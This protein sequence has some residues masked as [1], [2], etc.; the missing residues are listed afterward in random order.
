[1]VADADEAIGPVVERMYDRAYSQ[2]PVY[3][4][5]TLIGL[6]TS[7][8]IA[9]WLGSVQRTSRPSMATVADVLGVA[10]SGL[11]LELVDQDATVGQALSLFDRSMRSGTP[12]A[13]VLVTRDAS[14]TAQPLGI[15]TVGDL[16]RLRR[17]RDDLKS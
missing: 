16:P 4:G 3:R 10:E 12:L 1:M 8:A 14:T 11:P 9:R 2:V 5:N 15:L 17:F 7:D 6:L 13:A